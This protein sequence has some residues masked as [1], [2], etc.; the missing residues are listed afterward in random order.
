MLRRSRRAVLLQGLALGVTAAVLWWLGHNAAASLQ[1]HGISLGFTFLKQPANFEIGD[2]AWLRFSPEQSVGRAILVGLVNTARV[3]AVGCVLAIALGFIVG[4]VR[5]SPNP[6][7][8]G[9]MRTGVELMRNTPLLLLVLLVAASLHALPPTERALHPAPGVFLSE[10]G[11]VLPTLRVNGLSLWLG[12]A[13]GA[14]LL[15]R[16]S[17]G[18]TGWRTAVTAA[19]VAWVISLMA[20]RPTIELAHL[21][22]FNFTGGTTLSPEFAALVAALVLHHAAHI[23]EVVR[24]ALLAVPRGQRDAARALGLSRFQVLR[25]V[26]IPLALRAMV[27]LLATNCVSLVKNSSLAVAIGFPDLVSI[28]NT[29]GNQTGHNIETMLIMM[30]VYLSLSLSVAAALN[31]YN[32]V[33]LAQGTPAQ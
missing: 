8:S 15:M 33:L 18:R 25:L 16:R 3:S 31:R 24:G 4:I 10:R 12:V 26:T 9:L 29:A 19:A 13:T 27:P 23:S 7:A 22:G 14:T 17:L 5:L 20:R 6:A 1:R 28:L 32:A 30:A 2:T 21:D 11:L